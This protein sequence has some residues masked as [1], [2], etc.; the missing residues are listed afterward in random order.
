MGIAIVVIGIALLLLYFWDLRKEKFTTR[1]IVLI[2]LFAAISIVLY[3]IPLIKYPQGG[4]ITLFS[5]LPVMLLGV[6]YGRRE[7][8][9]CGLIFGFLKIIGGGGIINPA[10]FLLDYTLSTMVIG[11]SGM[12]GTDKK[13]KIFLGCI[14]VGFIAAGLN[15]L[16]GVLYYAQYTPKGMNI[17]VYSIVYN[18][19][20]TGVEA[21]I[22]SIFMMILPIKMLKERIGK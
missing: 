11:L 19:S 22:T 13:W 4:G 5:M 3:M 7:A 18:Y 1:K 14:V 9:T 16:S 6:I 8:L 17:W 10:E 2:G 21:L 15:T 12:F 20:S